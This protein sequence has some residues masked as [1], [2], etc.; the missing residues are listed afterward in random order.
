MFNFQNVND[1]EF[2]VLCK[3]ILERETGLKF[4]TYAKGRDGG[5][6]IKAYESESII[7]QVKHYIDSPVST[8]M[9]SLRK[10]L[11][12]VKKLSP[13]EYY[14]FVSKKLSNDKINEIFEIFEEFMSS[15]SCIYCLTDIN[16][17][18]DKEDNQDIVRKHYKLWLA[19]TNILSEISNRNIF[20]DS[21]ELLYEVEKE[22]NL[23]VETSGYRDALDI[24]LKHKLVILQGH[25]GVGKTTVSKMILLKLASE[26]FKV[27]YSSDSSIKDIKKV[28]SINRDIKE[29]ILIDDFLG[30]HYLDLKNTN[31]NEI[32]SLCQYV[33][34]NKNKFLIMNSRIT[35]YNEAL[36][37]NQ[38][39]MSFF[40]NE[41]EKI[42]TIDLD[43]ISY[44]EKA[45][46][47]YNHIYFKKLPVEHF[48]NLMINKRYRN[49][50]RHENYNPRIIEY[51]TKQTKIREV[52]P[53]DYYDFVMRKLKDP[54]DV[55]EEEF[56]Y[57][58]CEIDRILL[59]C[60]Y[61][62]TDKN[63]NERFLKESFSNWIKN[64]NVDMTIDN[65]RNCLSRLTNSM[66]N[67]IDYNGEKMIGVV[68]P[69]VNDFLYSRFKGNDSLIQTLLK[70]AVFYEQIE[71]LKKTNEKLVNRHIV[72]RINESKFN[73]LKGI[74][75]TIDYYFLDSISKFK[76]LDDSQKNS[77]ID[78]ILDSKT[79]IFPNNKVQNITYYENNNIILNLIENNKIYQ[80]YNLKRLIFEPDNIEFM[81]FYMKYQNILKLM[82][83]LEDYYEYKSVP[84]DID[85]LISN[86]VVSQIED[87]IFDE[88][89]ESLP[90]IIND[91]MENVDHDCINN[92][93]EGDNR[94]LIGLIEEE[95]VNEISLKVEE[96]ND[97][98]SNTLI[99]INVK[100]DVK[101]VCENL[102][103]EELIVD[104]MKLDQGDLYDEY[105]ES[106]YNG[107][108]ERIDMIDSIFDR[109][110]N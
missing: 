65:F 82:E 1:Y 88:M 28:L 78:I 76:I 16:E 70:N 100:I 26:G 107:Q 31:P 90:E 2:E 20:I 109:E 25:P 23:F 11:N 60:L 49:I 59:Y 35:I 85:E 66:I 68:N 41:E 43:N 6:D 81:L 33:I 73:E 89:N 57:R 87:V 56:N 63:I 79:Y 110:Y 42:Y 38:S 37:R 47:F 69:S 102:E 15:K 80:F 48:K 75:H 3:D 50:V 77:L 58:I 104:Y 9:S 95:I 30:Q 7:A 44:K 5:I 105:R 29:V 64:I 12:K 51:V 24:L 22:S 67:I 52:M 108:D 14:I 83:I 27:R 32:K 74:R 54:K 53:D 45:H 72:K 71:K 84:D 61:S 10:E 91:I 4:R 46:I 36:I 39:L 99:T 93:F 106:R 18:L 62:L 40:E 34:K 98:L 8:L 13:S 92:Y 97:E 21:E 103:Y 17:I 101:D 55:W 19:S 86:N 96:K 94:Y